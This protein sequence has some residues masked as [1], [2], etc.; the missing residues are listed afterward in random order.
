MRRFRAVWG[1]SVGLGL[2]GFALACVGTPARAQQK[3]QITKLTDVAFGTITDLTVDAVR[4]Q[5]VCV[6]SNTATKGYNV[7]ATGSGTGS[8]FTLTS[9]T[10]LLAYEVQWSSSSGQSS[11]TSLTAGTTLTGLKS[12]ATSATCTSGPLTTASLIVLIR[13]ATL[14]SATATAYSGTLTL[15]IGPE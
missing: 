12:T 9:G 10:H 15:L 3:V 8:A 14:S 2:A 1:I 11:G 4:S 7:R 13:T 6:Y 5:N